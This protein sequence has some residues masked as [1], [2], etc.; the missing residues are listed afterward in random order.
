VLIKCPTLTATATLATAKSKQLTLIPAYKNC[1]LGGLPVT[2]N[3]TGCD[4]NLTSSAETH[5]ECPEGAQIDFV[6][7][8][9]NEVKCTITVFSGSATGT[10]KFINETN[11]T[12]KKMDIRMLH[13]MPGL[14]YREDPGKGSCGIGEGINGEYGGEITFVATNTAGNESRDLTIN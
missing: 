4:W 12:T 10:T 3:F 6:V 11:P 8:E 1:S 13:S 7:K 2:V 5:T 14:Q 9:F